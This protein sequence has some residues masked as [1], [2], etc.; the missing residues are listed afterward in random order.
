MSRITLEA[1]PAA[2]DA[3]CR[4]GDLAPPPGARGFQWFEWDGPR[5]IVLLRRGDAVHAFINECPHAGAPLDLPPGQFFD[6]SH[7]HLECRMHGARFRIED[8]MCIAGP[9]VGRAL[10]RFAVSVVD[11]VVR[12]GD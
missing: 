3:L 5:R 11:G 2:G 7:T 1:K 8:G 9:C 4:L 12:A 6:E 10:K